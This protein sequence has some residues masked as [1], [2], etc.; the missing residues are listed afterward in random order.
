MNPDPGAGSH[1]CGLDSTLLE[2]RHRAPQNNRSFGIGVKGMVRRAIGRVLVASLA[3]ATPFIVH[4]T[5]QTLAEEP[6]THKYLQ[7]FVQQFSLSSREVPGSIVAQLSA[8]GRKEITRRDGV[9][10]RATPQG[11]LRMAPEGRTEVWTGKQ[12]LPVRSLTA[13]AAGPDGILW[14]GSAEGAACF[15]PNEPPATAGRWFYFWGRRY[16]PDNSVE[17]IVPEEGGAWMRTHTGIARIEFKPFDL[18]QKS[19]LFIQRLQ[20]RHNR[21]GYVADCDLLRPGDLASC[22]PAPSDND[23]LWTAIYV[24][25]ECFRYAVTRSPEALRNARLSLAALMRLES[26]TGIP[27]FPARALIRRGDY[28]DPEGEWHWTPDG[29][30]EWKGDTSS[31]ELVGHFFAYYV[32]GALLP[33]VSDRAAV[34]LVAGRIA[35]HL[36]DHGLNL[37]GPGGRV[38][39][40]GKY[41]PEYF[42]TP[43]GRVDRALNSLEILSHLRVAY[44]LTREQRFLRAYHRLA[45]ELGYLGNVTEFATQAPLEVNYSDEELTFLSFYPLLSLEDDPHLK[46]EYQR[47]LEGLWRRTRNEN[48]P[49]WNFIYAAGTGVTKGYDQQEALETLERIPLET[50]C[51]TV[52]NSQRIDLELDPRRGRFEEKQ[53]WRAIPP[54]QR[55]VMKWNGNPFEL[56]GGNGGR[57]EDDGAFFL[58]PYWLGRYHRLVK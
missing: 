58:L 48:N 26:I 19:A 46:R 20:A 41:S 2:T 1:V 29:E 15:K 22:R 5:R 50:I 44:H 33:D 25:A 32:A 3:A 31:D 27:G 11:L 30:W 10:W 38:T 36:L 34:G 14:I 13:L 6:A 28:R 35:T 45:G 54:D 8:P 42:Q 7:I 39:T 56:D 17:N 53:S 24:A 16:L 47:A 51:W 4:P 43:D 12:G 40:W 9:R 21:Y 18:D 55:R 23:G 52:K 37:V 57:S 49:L